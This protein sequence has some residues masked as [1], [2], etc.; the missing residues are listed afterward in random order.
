MAVVGARKSPGK[1]KPPAAGEK[2]EYPARGKIPITMP[3]VISWIGS[4]IGSRKLLAPAEPA[5]QREYP[6][7]FTFFRKRSAFLSS[8]RIPGFY[9]YLCS[10]SRVPGFAGKTGKDF[11]PLQIQ[12]QPNIPA[13]KKFP[14][15]VCRQVKGSQASFQPTTSFS[16]VR[17]SW[18][19]PIF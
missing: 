11:L 15:R 14:F 19:G 3:H 1:Q 16:K 10:L 6:R 7:Q 18:S 12:V 4:K 2:P 8:N 5:D 13:W 9:R 17:R